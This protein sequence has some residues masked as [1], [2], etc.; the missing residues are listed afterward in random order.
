MGEKSVEIKQA[1]EKEIWVGE[2]R[3]YLTNDN[4][5]YYVKTGGFDEKTAIDSIEAMRTLNEHAE[6]EEHG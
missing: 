1:N 2:N 6:G 3:I 5:L 4:D